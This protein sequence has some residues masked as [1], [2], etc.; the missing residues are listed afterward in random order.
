MSI[1]SC[2]KQVKKQLTQ[3]TERAR[4]LLLHMNRCFLR[5]NLYY[6]SC[7]KQQMQIDPNQHK[8]LACTVRQDRQLKV[9]Y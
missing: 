7:R 5:R 3:L 6:C 8:S 1:N 9:I 4:S 2:L